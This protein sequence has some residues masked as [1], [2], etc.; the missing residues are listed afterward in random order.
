MH[1]ALYISHICRSQLFYSS[2]LLRHTTMRLNNRVKMAEICERNGWS[3]CPSKDGDWNK[4]KAIGTTEQAAT[5]L[6]DVNRLGD[7]GWY[8]RR[9]WK[10]WWQTRGATTYWKSAQPRARVRP[11]AERPMWPCHSVYRETARVERT[12]SLLDF[13]P[14]PASISNTTLS[15][16]MNDRKRGKCFSL[17]GRS[18]HSVPKVYPGWA[19]LWTISE[20]DLARKNF[21]DGP[22]YNPSDRSMMR[23]TTLWFSD[24]PSVAW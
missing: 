16:K 4:M 14:A 2:E 3:L 19:G 9:P 24:S 8:L 11:M 21:S 13:L 5:R 23:V 17:G 15:R 12:K 18:S 6:R 7:T 20:Y 22:A 10:M 1:F